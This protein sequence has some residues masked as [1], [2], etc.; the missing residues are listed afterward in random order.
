VTGALWKGFAHMVW[1]IL[2]Q[3]KLTKTEHMDAMDVA[4]YD[5]CKYRVWI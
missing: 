2:T 1:D 3:M 5:N 4:G